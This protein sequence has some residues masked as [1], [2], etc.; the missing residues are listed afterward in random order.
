MFIYS[1]S[2]THTQNLNAVIN[3]LLD[4]QAATCEAKATVMT[5]IVGYCRKTTT[6]L[7]ILQRASR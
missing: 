3:T 2:L 6:A 5:A 7:L 4:I 1:L